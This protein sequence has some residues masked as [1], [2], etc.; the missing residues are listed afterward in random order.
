MASFSSRKSIRKSPISE[1]EI[2]CQSSPLILTFSSNYRYAMETEIFC[3][4]SPL[5]VTF[6][7]NYRY[8]CLHTVCIGFYDG[9]PLKGM[10]TN[11]PFCKDSRGVIKF[12]RSLETAGSYMKSYAAPAG[13]DRKYVNKIENFCHR[14]PWSQWD[15]GIGFCGVIETAGFDS[16]VSLRPRD[17]NFANDYLD[18]LSEN[19]AICKTA[20]GRESGP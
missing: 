8:A 5:I 6:S 19:E 11:I 13:N 16:A 10:W 15:R 9:F 3:Q 14:F 18:F 7:S 17:P 2:F 20:L 12:L 4:S 1:T